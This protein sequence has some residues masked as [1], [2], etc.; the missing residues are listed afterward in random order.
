MAFNEL[1][2]SEVR[3]ALRR[4][5][6]TVTSETDGGYYVTV[7]AMRDGGS[8]PVRLGQSRVCVRPRTARRYATALVRAALSAS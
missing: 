1:T 3:R 6:F 8:A 5:V 4:G 2:Q 7:F